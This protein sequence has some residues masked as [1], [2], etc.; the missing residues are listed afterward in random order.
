LRKQGAWH[1]D[2]DHL[3]DDG[4]ALSPHSNCPSFRSI[5]WPT[6]L[7]TWI[8]YRTTPSAHVSTPFCACM[9]FLGL[10]EGG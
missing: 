3:E 1:G 8:A 5:S 10:V 7:I 9:R 4:A 2:F 6:W